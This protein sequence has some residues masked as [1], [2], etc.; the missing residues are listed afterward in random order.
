MFGASVY[1][2]ARRPMSGATSVRVQEHHR[3]RHRGNILP[4]NSMCVSGSTGA[5]RLSSATLRSIA[6][7]NSQLILKLF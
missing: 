5:P 4:A 1:F 6:N 2:P 3:S 7:Q